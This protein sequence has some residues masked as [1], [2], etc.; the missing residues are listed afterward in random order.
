MAII[1]FLKLG[2]WFILWNTRPWWT[3]RLGAIMREYLDLT[4]PGKGKEYL[5]KA[6]K[7][8]SIPPRKFKVDGFLKDGEVIDFG[9]TRATVLHTPGIP[10]VILRS[11]LSGRA[12]YSVAILT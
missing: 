10:R 2:Y 8:R 11:T 1:S 7:S 12:L 3:K 6:R 5:A 4:K 9:H